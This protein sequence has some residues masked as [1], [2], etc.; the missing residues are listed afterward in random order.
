MTKQP[1]LPA[2]CTSKEKHCCSCYCCYNQCHCYCYSCYSI[3][4]FNSYCQILATD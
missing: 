1:R 3:H 2:A 4:G